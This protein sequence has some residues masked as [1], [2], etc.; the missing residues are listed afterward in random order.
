[1]PGATKVNDG[2]Y[3]IVDNKRQGALISKDSWNQSVFPGAELSM[4][5]D[6]LDLVV[7]AS[8]TSLTQTRPL[9]GTQRRLTEGFILL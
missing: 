8:L 6:V 5:H 7:P 2:K 9:D 4:E 1:V 3:H